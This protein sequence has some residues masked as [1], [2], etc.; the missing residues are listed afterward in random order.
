MN[1]TRLWAWHP[2]LTEAFMQARM[3]IPA[4]NVFSKREL[5]VMVCSMARTLGD[6]YCALAWGKRL[7]DASSQ[8]TA[9][10]VLTTGDF[11]VLSP[12]EIALAHWTRQIVKDP[13]ATTHADV[14][15]L[16][17]AGLSEREIF[18]AT[19]FIAL[20]LA[21]ST[22]NDALGVHP[23]PQVAEQAPAVV[24]KAVSFGR[25]PAPASQT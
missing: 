7:A 16:R 13:N 18:D 15:K 10:A 1:L 3:M 20:R 17:D 25:Q 22:V 23:D 4:S 8:E 11:P 21:F 5:A 12:R 14:D 9:A 2:E 6:S 19:V 24:R